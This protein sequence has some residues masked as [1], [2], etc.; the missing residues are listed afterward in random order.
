MSQTKECIRTQYGHVND[1]LPTT[2]E[3]IGIKAPEY[4]RN[5]RQDTIQGTSLVYSF[6][7]KDAVTKHRDQYY[8]IFGSRSIYKN[9]W[10]AET[11]HHP[12]IIDLT[13]YKL[14][15]DSLVRDYSKDVWE[16]YNLDDDFN[17]RV[18][19]SK[20]YPEK[21]IEL[22]SLFDAEAQQNHIYPFIDWEDVFRRRIHHVNFTPVSPTK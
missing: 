15:K 3:F 13:R 5:I 4:L 7:D 18:D 1:L 19:L 14:G 17:E 11:Y 6:N 12:D 16:L 21:L 10:K 2:L 9:G 22:Q 20:K 8:Y